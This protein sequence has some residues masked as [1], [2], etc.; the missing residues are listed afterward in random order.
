MLMSLARLAVVIL[1]LLRVYRNA[2]AAVV[3]LV[4]SLS[5]N[6]ALFFVADRRNAF[7]GAYS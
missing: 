7:K 3:N 1:L 5:I 6:T 2:F 4:G